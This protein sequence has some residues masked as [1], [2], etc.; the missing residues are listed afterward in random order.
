[1]TFK[2][3]SDVVKSQGD[4]IKELEKKMPSRASKQEVQLSF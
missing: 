3:L 2:A 1:M 4:I